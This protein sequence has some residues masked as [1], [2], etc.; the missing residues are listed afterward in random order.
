MLLVDTHEKVVTKDEE[1]KLQIARSRPHS[2][3]IKEQVGTFLLL[4]IA[5]E[6]F[7]ETEGNFFM[8]LTNITANTFTFFNELLFCDNC[9]LELGGGFAYF[10][11]HSAIYILQFSAYKFICSVVEYCFQE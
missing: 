2:L 9:F 1:L 7:P 3:W 8:L 5:K 6:T 4:T 11:V 10:V